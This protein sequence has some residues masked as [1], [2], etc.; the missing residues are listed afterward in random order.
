MAVAVVL[1]A[2]LACC[3]VPG[4]R[5]IF[6]T[7]KAG[8]LSDQ[9][10]SLTG[11]F[12]AEDN[13]MA[14]VEGKTVREQ[15][16]IDGVKILKIHKDRVEF[17][18]AG[19]TWSQGMPGADDTVTGALPVMLELGTHRCP[20]CRRMM[21]VLQELRSGY[22]HKFRVRYIDVD[23]DGQTADKYGISRI[24]TQIFLDRKGRELYR[25]VGFFS[26]EEI[27]A[28]WRSLGVKL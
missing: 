28:T 10:L 8:G 26:K 13:P 25:H 24:P 16:V 12:Y 5:S 7:A 11:I 21:P 20:P 14:I 2:V 3:F 27:L 9:T 18:N 22:S 1:I 4:L 19:R 15:D 17:Q 6:S 23:K